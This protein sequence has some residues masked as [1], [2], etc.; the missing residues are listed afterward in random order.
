MKTPSMVQSFQSLL[1]T[2]L[3]ATSIAFSSSATAEWTGDIEGGTVV[4]GDDK[5]T[6]LRFKA[7]NSSRPF[8]Q[9]VYADWLRDDNKNSTYEA[10]YQPK[11][12]FSE[13]AYAF[14]EGSYAT[15]SD[16]ET[17]SIIKLFGGV[18]LQLLSNA[19]Q[20]LYVEAGAGQ[21]SVKSGLDDG[22]TI[23]DDSAIARLGAVQTLS[24][25]LKF[26][27]DGEYTTTD[28]LVQTSAEAGIALRIT[29][30]A[31]KYTYRI[32]SNKLGDEKSENI[33]DS[34]VSFQYGF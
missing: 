23:T 32:R 17:D 21:T 25:L 30:G 10:G 6:R 18:G 20:S 15:T 4:H 7:S 3:F 28:E 24:D 33:T 1:L 12:W 31:I 2:T 16:E 34:Y 11:F 14:G 22:E 5:G 13:Q 29:G 26:E 8:S 27:L 19:S 9:T